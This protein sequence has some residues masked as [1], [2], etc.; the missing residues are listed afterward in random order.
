MHF[1]ITGHTGFKGTWLSLLLNERGHQV[2]GISLEPVE[3]SLFTRSGASSFLQDNIYCDIRDTQK[4]HKC[5]QDINPDV[6]IHLAA[7][8]L[9]RHSYKF[10]IKTFETNV[11]GT[12]NV[13]M[14]SES[15]TNLKAQLIVTTDKVYKNINKISGYH[16]SDEIDGID[17]YSASKVTADKLTQAWVK[18]FSKKTTAVA[19]AGNVIGGGDICEDRLIPDLVYHLIND[20]IPSLRFPNAVR[21]WQHV[22][23]CLNGYLSLVNYMVKNQQ[24]GIWNFGP[25]QT[26]LKTVSTV[27][28]QVSKTWG[29]N[30]K[31]IK[32]DEI[33]PYETSLLILDSAK[34][35]Q[36]LGWYDKLSFEDAINWTTLWYKSVSLGANVLEETIVNIKNFES[37][38]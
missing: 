7:Q 23:D 17:P 18:S 32:S 25:D 29:T 16:E 30:K 9:V 2:S 10:P 20:K 33:N 28:E 8:S 21:P 15:V 35:K 12:L 22:L 14:A 13:L 4:I 36:T 38:K 27:A 11:T 6:V 5:F 31:W 24:G 3:N 19:R 26:E 1:L 37:L 34:A